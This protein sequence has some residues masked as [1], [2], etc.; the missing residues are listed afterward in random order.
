MSE[1][2]YIKVRDVMTPGIH[3]IDGLATIDEAMRQMKEKN[4]GALIVNRRDESDEYGFLTVQAIARRVIE[5]NLSPERVSVYEIMEKP[6]LT[7]HGDMNIRYAIRLLERVNK[8]R[9][10]VIDNN[11]AA[12]IVTI[13]DM[14]T[15]YLDAIQ[16]KN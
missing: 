14:V 9:A 2:P 13:F 11:E 12:G 3:M 15:R 4:F 8:L 1:K 16:N 7:V 10:I 5:P 6:C